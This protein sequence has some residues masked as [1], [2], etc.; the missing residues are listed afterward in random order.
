M[1]GFGFASFLVRRVA[2]GALVLLLV[3][4]LIFA[5]CD[6]LPGDVA[7]LSLGQYATEDAVR[8]LRQEMGLNRPAA[9]RYLDWLGGLLHGDWGRSIGTRQP[10]AGM[11]SERLG[12]TLML[13]GLAAAIAVP[14]ALLLGF[15]MA[16]A[17]RRPFDRGASIVVLALSA[18][19]EFL[20]A[21]CLVALFAVQLRWLPAISY[22]SAGADFMQTARSLVLP[23]ATLVLVLLAQIAR[24]SRAVMENLLDRPFVEMAV[25]KGA[26][27]WRVMR[28][29][30]LV[31]A[32]VPLANV[33]A[34]NVAYLVSG[35]L[36]VET[37]FAFPGLTRLMVDAVTTRDMPV[38]QACALIFCAAYVLLILLADIVAQVFDP[39]GAQQTMGELH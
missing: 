22:V 27:R 36:V 11:L 30:V 12:N 8:T 13:A 5:A 26:S 3:S 25:L 15:A 2:L 37:V 4:L 35:V 21:T 19:P 18:M 23:V 32:V 10:V 16:M 33:V 17:A 9:E 24:M 20:I 38:V 31:N 14:L 29:H 7:R 6:L 1:A 28:R 34:L 39:Q